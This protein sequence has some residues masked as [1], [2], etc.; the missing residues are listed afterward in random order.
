MANIAIPSRLPGSSSVSAVWRSL[1]T[2]RRYPI[3]PVTILLF[4]LVLPALFANWVAPH[5]PIRGSLSNRLVPPFWV[6]AEGEG[7]YAKP[8]GSMEHILGTDKQGRDI[9]SRIV[10]E[11]IFNWPGV[12]L[13]AIDALRAKDFQVVQSVVIFFAAVYIFANLLVDILYGYLDPRIRYTS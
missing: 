13:L 5:D 12:G 9:L 4:V 7:L 6:E 8:G 3:F 1:G 10:I 2:A 11:T